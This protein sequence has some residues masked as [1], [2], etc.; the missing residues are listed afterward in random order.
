[1]ID[2]SLSEE[3][4]VLTTFHASKVLRVD[5]V[6]KDML[7]MCR[8]CIVRET[9]PISITVMDHG[10]PSPFGLNAR[11]M[12]LSLGP[13]C[14]QVTTFRARNDPVECG[15]FA[16]HAFLPYALIMTDELNSDSLNTELAL[17]L[18]SPSSR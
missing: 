13:G 1:M 17:E 16:R 2:A 8:C 5:S 4:E 10:G 7:A 11:C 14:L 6:R 3:V 12:G 18:E 15:W 9:H